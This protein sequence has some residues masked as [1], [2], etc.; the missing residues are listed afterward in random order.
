M[1]FREYFSKHRRAF[2]LITVLIAVSPVFGVILT[3]IVGY[4]EP[5]DLAA[6]ALGL[7]ETTEENNWTPLIDYTVPG[8]PDWLG[9]IVSGVIGSVVVLLLAFLVLKLLR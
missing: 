5:L 8:L 6:E 9:Y 1:S 3:G 7:K 4:H 2:T